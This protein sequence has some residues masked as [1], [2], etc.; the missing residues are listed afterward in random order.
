LSRGGH[1]PAENS[2]IQSA[3]DHASIYPEAP[4]R[5]GS[6][7]VCALYV[8][9]REDGKLG[10]FCSEGLPELLTAAVPCFGKSVSEVAKSLSFLL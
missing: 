3:E 1:Q 2:G 9:T 10:T 4:E 8:G 7:C 6:F 5:E